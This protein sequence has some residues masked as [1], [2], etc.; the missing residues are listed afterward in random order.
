[1]EKVREKLLNYFALFGSAGTLIC[2]ALPS[3]L[4]TLGLG[5]SLSGLITTFPQITWISQYKGIV[6]TLSGVLILA[7]G[8]LQYKAKDAPCP[9]DEKKRMACQSARRLSVGIW[10][11]SALTWAVGA[12]FAFLIVYL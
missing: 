3:L 10:I 12:F 11:V 7:S 2:C 1:M 5:A 9:I 4:V 6:F 8:Y